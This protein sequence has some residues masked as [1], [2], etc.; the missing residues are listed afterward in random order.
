MLIVVF[1]AGPR[2]GHKRPWKKDCS[3]TRQ[4]PSF[5][6]DQVA[7]FVELA[8]QGSLRR[9][10][11]ALHIT[12]QGVRNRLLTLEK[13]LQVEL[14]R[15]RQGMRHATP[16]TQQGRQFLHHAVAFLERACEL[17]DLFDATSQP[18]DV[19]VAA[20]QYLIQYVLID[21]ARRFHA[22][23]PH[24]RIRLSTH[25]EQEIENVLLRDPDVAIG[26]AAP[27]EPSP[28]LQYQ[29]MFSMNWSVI[30]PV[31]HR[32]SRLKTIRLR[33]LV[34]EPLIVFERG[35]TG[36]QHVLDA[37]H[38]QELSPQVHMET[39]TT[40]IVVRM[41]E[42]G[43]G[44][45]I[46]PL[47]PSGAVTRGRKVAIRA[48]ADPIRPIHSGIL[49]RRGDRLSAATSEFVGFVRGN[50]VSEGTAPRRSKHLRMGPLKNDQR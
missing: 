40:E 48:I 47:L 27:Y 30:T 10:G 19:H 45:S 2:D 42:A 39:T 24:I 9:A 16:L 20:S 35:S 41:V 1:M 31:R 7:A 28:E 38:E 21:A 5:S 4:V 50:S 15:K 32:V 44:I 6:T 22:R 36:R 49:T 8:R 34:A 43:L 29:H 17:A 46:V 25:A 3:M 12:E 26:V 23:F 18:R 33:D 11:E 14:Y 37:F 13:Q